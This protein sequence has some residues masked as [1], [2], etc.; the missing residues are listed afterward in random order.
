M[1]PV[2]GFPF[3]PFIM[4]NVVGDGQPKAVRILQM[5]TLL[6]R[7]VFSTS[8]GTATGTEARLEIGGSRKPLPR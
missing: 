8:L 7:N 4:E 3:A 2:L 5:E 6:N 1:A